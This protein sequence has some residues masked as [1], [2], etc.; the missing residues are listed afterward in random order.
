MADGYMV[1]EAGMINFDS[2]NIYAKWVNDMID[3]QEADGNVPGIVPT[4][5]HWDSNWAGPMWDAAIFITPHLLY[6]YS[7][8]TRAIET[9]YPAAK[10][11]LEYLQTREEANGTINHGLGDWLL[12]KA[13]TP[14]DFM[15]TCFYYWDNVLMA[16]MARLTGREPEAAPYEAKAEKLKV[17]INELFFDPEKVCYSNGTQLSYALPL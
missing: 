17:L 6:Q 14:V 13:Q 4:S 5:W 1:Q 3:A 7:G 2:R 15:A 9:I 12:Y 10:R 16:Q 11:Y 8:D